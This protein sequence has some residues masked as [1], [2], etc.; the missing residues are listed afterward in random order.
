MTKEDW[1][2]DKLLTTF[3]SFVCALRGYLR[4]KHLSSEFVSEDKLKTTYQCSRCDATW[5][6]T[7]KV[8]AKGAA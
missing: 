1:I 8:K 5:N 7:R 2:L 4:G 3:G 6:R